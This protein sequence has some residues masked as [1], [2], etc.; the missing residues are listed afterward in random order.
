MELVASPPT[1]V[2]KE[3]G[4]CDFG[5]HIAKTKTKRSACPERQSNLRSRR[6]KPF[7]LQPSRL[8]RIKNIL[9]TFQVN[10]FRAAPLA[11]YAQP[12]GLLRVF[13]SRPCVMSRHRAGQAQLEGHSLHFSVVPP[14]NFQS[15]FHPNPHR[16]ALCS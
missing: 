15:L 1:A 13:C 4:F 14:L 12:G 5:L 11:G 9:H 8:H 3:L 7:P 10:L 6:K 16:T 2:L